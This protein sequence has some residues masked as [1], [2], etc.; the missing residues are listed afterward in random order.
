MERQPIKGSSRIAAIGYDPEDFILE[1][2]FHGNSV[3]QYKPFTPEG[4]TSFMKAESKG[5][6][7]EHYVKNDPDIECTRMN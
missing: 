5:K 7:F 6:F 4:Y 2:E 1:V 3:Y